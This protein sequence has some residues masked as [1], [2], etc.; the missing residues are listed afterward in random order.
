MPY[1]VQL[2]FWIIAHVVDVN[3]EEGCKV[4][5][6]HALSK[7]KNVAAL[8]TSAVA[9]QILKISLNQTCQSKNF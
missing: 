6:K 2:H 3:T 8:K 9:T 5:L 4:S 7:N 1:Y